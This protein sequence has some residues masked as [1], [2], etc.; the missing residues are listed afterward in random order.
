MLLS[1]SVCALSLALACSLAPMAF[2]MFLASSCGH[3]NEDAAVAASV[4]LSAAA[5]VPCN[6]TSWKSSSSQHESGSSGDV[7]DTTTSS[8]GCGTINGEALNCS[9]SSHHK[10]MDGRGAVPEGVNFCK[11]RVE[12]RLF[13]IYWATFST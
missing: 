6:R 11:G 4:L 10:V 5:E 8:A 1:L 13:P 9:N 7:D 12:V 2:P 3:S